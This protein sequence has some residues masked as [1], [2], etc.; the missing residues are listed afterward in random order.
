MRVLVDLAAI[1]KH[2]RIDAFREGAALR[3]Q[4]LPRGIE[5]VVGQIRNA[6]RP[7]ELEDQPAFSLVLK[8]RSVGNALGEVTTLAR[9]HVAVVRLSNAL[10]RDAELVECMLVARRAIS[11]A[12]DE[13]RE[14][15]AQTGNAGIEGKCFRQNLAFAADRLLDQRNIRH[16]AN[17]HFAR[18]LCLRYEPEPAYPN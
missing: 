12:M 2:L 15:H 1:R 5:F 10:E 3:D 8:L 16:A 13:P 11:L 9:S 7:L 14:V 18:H 4:T 17:R 6:A